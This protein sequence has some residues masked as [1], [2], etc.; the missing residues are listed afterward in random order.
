MNKINVADLLYEV[1][2]NKDIYKPGIDLVNSGLLDS[3][4]L[5]ELFAK[6]EDY[7]VKLEPTRINRDKLRSIKG[8]EE[9]VDEYLKSH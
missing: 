6:L 4:A 5:I 2:E 3:F 9:L 8:I 1:C 7:G